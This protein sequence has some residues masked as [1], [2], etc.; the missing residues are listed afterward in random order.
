[1]DTAL[2][3]PRAAR[4]SNLFLQVWERNEGA[5]RFYERAGFKIA[6]RTKFTVASGIAQDD[7][8]IM[9]RQCSAPRK[10]ST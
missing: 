8:F 1:M 5:I 4:A 10:D 9:V 6:G 7:D 3:H 2:A